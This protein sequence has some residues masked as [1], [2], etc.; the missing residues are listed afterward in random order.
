MYNPDTGIP[1]GAGHYNLNFTLKDMG[2][3]GDLQIQVTQLS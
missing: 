2:D 3:V 1:G